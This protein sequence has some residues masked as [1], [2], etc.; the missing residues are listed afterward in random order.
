M[1]KKKSTDICNN[2]VIKDQ[3]CFSLKKI[4]N[5]C[6]RLLSGL[7]WLRQYRCVMTS[8]SCYCR[9]ARVNVLQLRCWHTEQL[10]RIMQPFYPLTP[11]LALRTWQQLIGSCSICKHSESVRAHSPRG[12]RVQLQ[13]GRRVQEAELPEASGETAGLRHLTDLTEVINP[14]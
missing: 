8:F 12:I 6:C 4:S 11:T 5:I 3:R 2:L 13:R 7:S 1:R 10:C 9:C 14:H